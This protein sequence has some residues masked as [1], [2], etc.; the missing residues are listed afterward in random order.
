VPPE[1]SRPRRRRHTGGRD[2]PPTADAIG[3]PPGRQGDQD[4]ADAHQR[5]EIADEALCPGFRQSQHVDDEEEQ[6]GVECQEPTPYQ[7]PIHKPRTE[8]R[9]A[10]AVEGEGVAQAESGAAGGRRDRRHPPDRPGRYQHS[11]GDHRRG[12]AHGGQH[13]AAADEA[14]GDLPAED[15]SQNLQRRLPSG[16]CPTLTFGHVI[17]QERLAR[18]L[19]GVRRKL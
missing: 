5:R 16:R 14:T 6:E 10:T 13:L 11:H 7:H 19:D 17:R 4:Q 8:R 3:Q 2:Q 1:Q 15:E 18:R 9:I 12:D